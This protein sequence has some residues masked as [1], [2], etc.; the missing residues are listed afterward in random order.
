MKPKTKTLLK[1]AEQY[2]DDHDKSIGFTLQYMQD[3]AH[4]DLDT[5]IEYLQ[6]NFED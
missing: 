2:C 3:V 4:V 5:A 6:G 1:E